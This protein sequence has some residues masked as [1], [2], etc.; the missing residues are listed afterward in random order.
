MIVMLFAGIGAQ[1]H[2]PVIDAV[3]VTVIVGAAVAYGL[4]SNRNLQGGPWRS[5]WMLL[6]SGLLCVV[7]G[8]LLQSVYAGGP[9]TQVG[10]PM[11]LSTGGDLLAILGLVSLIH[12]RMPERSTDA[13]AEALLSTLALGFVILALVVVPSHGR[14]PGFQVPALVAPLFD[15]I[16]LW[17]ASCLVSL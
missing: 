11:V 13:L 16:L 5:A 8:N 12:Q 3:V 2:D 15:I 4:Q 17:L 14:R 9:P 6:G 10:I 7:L 1:L